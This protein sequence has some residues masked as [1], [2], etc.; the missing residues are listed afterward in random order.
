M[1]II[2][3]YCVNYSKNERKNIRKECI[4]ADNNDVMI[5]R[6][7]SEALKSEFDKEIQSE[8]FGFNCTIF[9]M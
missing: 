7:Y 6:N 8:S 3:F 4:L 2:G 9:N 1:H 5:E